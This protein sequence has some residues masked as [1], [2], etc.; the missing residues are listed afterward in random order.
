MYYKLCRG[1]II[2]YDIQRCD[3]FEDAMK[4]IIELR[5]KVCSTNSD[6][7]EWINPNININIHAYYWIWKLSPHLVIVFAGNKADMEE[8][9]V[10]SNTEAQEFAALHN[11]ISMESSSVSGMNAHN[12]FTELGKIM[13]IYIDYA[14]IYS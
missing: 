14:G 13:Y 2:I 3:S 7:N 1:A 10:I 4:W 12:C 5:E 8:N 6:V 9:R 11:L